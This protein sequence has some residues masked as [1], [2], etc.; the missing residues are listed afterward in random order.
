[1]A[2]VC[3]QLLT[4]NPD[5][6]YVGLGFPKQERLIATLAPALPG[7]WFVACGAAIPFAAGSLPRAP[8]WMRQSGLEWLFRLISEPR[9]LARRYLF[10]DAP[11]AMRLL[12]TC[13]LTRIHALPTSNPGG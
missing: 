11:Y 9:R 3:D 6:V 1:M 2:K 4:A 7:A 13:L 5:I 10:D 12:A 8:A